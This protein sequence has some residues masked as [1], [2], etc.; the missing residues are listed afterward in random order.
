MTNVFH[1]QCLFMASRNSALLF[2]GAEKTGLVQHR[3]Q[4][5]APPFQSVLLN[6][7]WQN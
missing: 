4:K 5:P 2:S 6:C 1:I 3:S 7:F